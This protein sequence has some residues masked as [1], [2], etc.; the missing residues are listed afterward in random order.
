MEVMKVP[1]PGVAYAAQTMK[2][3]SFLAVTELL[4]SALLQGIKI[5]EVPATLTS[6]RFG[7]SKMK[8]LNVVCSHLGYVAR[9]LPA[10]FAVN[11][12]ERAR[13]NSCVCQDLPATSEVVAPHQS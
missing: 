13:I 8:T 11:S 3:D 5:A 12:R 4:V 9:L 2:S 10:R 1:Q 6:R 7:V